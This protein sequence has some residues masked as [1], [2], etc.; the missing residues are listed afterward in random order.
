MKSTTYRRKIGKSRE[1]KSFK[2]NNLGKGLEV[3]NEESSPTLA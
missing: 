2:I 1:K 3:G